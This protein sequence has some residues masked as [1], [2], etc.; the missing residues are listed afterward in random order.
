[1]SITGFVFML[2]FLGAL[3]LALARHPIFGLYAYVTVFYVHPPSRWWGAFLPDL[4]WS[5]LAAVVT[6]I[7]LWLHK[8][9]T[10]GRA[11]WYSNVPAQLLILYTVW[12]WVQ[13]GWALDQVAHREVSVLFTK[14]IILFYLIYRLVDSFTELR[15]FMLVHIAGCL[16]L[17]WLAFNANVSDRL[18]GVGGPGIDEANTLAMQLAT[19][20][21]IGAMMILA[22]RKWIQWACIVAMPFVLNGIVLTRSRGAFL[23]IVCGGI[24]MWFLKPPSY[25]RAFYGFAA[26]GVV[27]F[28]VLAPREFWERMGTITAAVQENME[29]DTSA[30]SRLVLIEAQL[31]MAKIYPFGTGHRG[32]EVLSPQYIDEKYLANAPGTENRARSSHNTFMTALVEQGIPG[33]VMFGVLWLWC[34]RTLRQLKGYARDNWSVHAGAMIAG[35]GGALGILFVSGM[36]VDYLKVEIQTWL[37]A[38]LASLAAIMHKEKASAPAKEAQPPLAV[39]A[40][41]GAQ[42][43]SAGPDRARMRPQT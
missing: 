30:E 8:P 3:G 37:V 43:M 14:Y 17:G 20:V 28:F 39:P 23:G 24:A 6:L 25:K 10:K 13:H 1:V 31:R 41:G 18:D 12:L 40:G 34:V 2:F 5:L 35:I 42:I 4:R 32:T 16:Y 9:A 22:E 38:L 33:A 19:G 29:V 11:P 26:L 21:A 27:L 15:R 7:A 36:F